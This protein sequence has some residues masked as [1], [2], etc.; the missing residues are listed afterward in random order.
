MNNIEPEE[1]EALIQRIMKSGE[2]GRSKTYAAI[3]NYLVDCSMTGINPKEITIAIDVLGRDATFDVAK[4]SIVRVH[5]YHLRNKL[6]A[7]FLKHGKSEKYRIDIP[8]GQYI[9]TSVLNEEVIDDGPAKS[10]T[11]KELSR[12]SLTPWLIALSIILLAA[13]LWSGR[14][15]QAETNA[16][17]ELSPNYP[18]AWQAI[19]GNET[20]ILIVIGDYYIVG[21][22]DERGNVR[23]MVRE[24]SI[25][26]QE[27]LEFEQSLGTTLSENYFNLDLSYIPTSTAFAL[28]QIMPVFADSQRQV[29]IK[30]MSALST[31]DLAS[32]HI[33]YL[34][35]LSGLGSIEDL[36]FAASG[37]SVGATYDELFDLESS[38]SFYSSSGLSVGENS[39]QDYGMIS[40]FPT[41]NG[42]QFMLIAGMRD[43]GLI[44]VSQEAINFKGLSNL[45]KSLENVE[46]STGAGRAY[47][48]LFEVFGY[49]GT[50]FDASL[51]Y[52]KPLE[53][54]VIWEARLIS[55][56]GR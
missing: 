21:E 8:K 30:M 56:Q 49:D 16:M 46:G 19:L 26:S 45:E 4:D 48:A 24:F 20:P 52:S 55:P 17:A 14:S 41:P 25:N 2:L 33:V 29:S 27:D 13:N 3:L 34:G 50:N 31:A 23:R 11:G 43:E 40:T 9:I 1:L 47:E 32:S 28:A 10:I 37:L 42:N 18:E 38:E 44:N 35:Y 15:K 39:F 5:I 7:Y 36:M 53:T 51:I 22:L 54:D 12:G 6:K